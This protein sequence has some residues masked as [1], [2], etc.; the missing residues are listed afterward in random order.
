M[1]TVVDDD[2]DIRNA[3]DVEW[4]MATRLD[5][6][7]GIVV[8]DKIFGHGLNPSFPD[9]LGAK[10][11]FDATRAFP[12]IY[13]HD[14]ATYKKVSL[15]GLDIDTPDLRAPGAGYGVPPIAAAGA[16]QG[17]DAFWDAVHARHMREQGGPAVAATKA[18]KV[19]DFWESVHARHMA[20]RHMPPPPK[21]TKGGAKAKTKAKRKG[22]GN[23][24]G[25]RA[26]ETA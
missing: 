24:S 15:T 1:V 8:I 17:V 20:E 3:S 13:E 26:G 7:E 14:R 2:V 21:P 5:P 22:K 6:N 12:H 9:Y 19:T 16:G 18:E 10:V 11:G 4:A 25:L 23:G